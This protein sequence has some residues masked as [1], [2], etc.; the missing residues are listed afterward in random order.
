MRGESAHQ[1]TW[2]TLAE[3]SD[4]RKIEMAD[5]K[6]R[7]KRLWNKR[8]LTP[9]LHR[10]WQL[11]SH[12]LS[13]LT[14]RDKATIE[15]HLK[16]VSLCHNKYNAAAVYF[17]GFVVSLRGIQCRLEADIFSGIPRDGKQNHVIGTGQEKMSAGVGGTGNNTMIPNF[18]HKHE[19]ERETSKLSLWKIQSG[20]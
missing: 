9:C 13:T 15:N 11:S 3:Q 7:G 12:G 14:G 2:W 5:K 17:R 18:I 19:H 20:P 4:N 10:T 16:F 1:C 6:T 8:R